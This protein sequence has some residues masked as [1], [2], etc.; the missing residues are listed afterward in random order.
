MDFGWELPEPY[1]KIDAHFS[2]HDDESVVDALAVSHYA[3]LCKELFPLLVQH[4][5]HEQMEMDDFSVITRLHH[6]MLLAS[7]HSLF[8]YIIE[9]LMSSATHFVAERPR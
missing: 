4:T 1:S 9:L 5:S 3:Q 7:R 8:T 6:N 2:Y